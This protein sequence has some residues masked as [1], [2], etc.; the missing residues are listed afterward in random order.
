MTLICQVKSYIKN[1]EEFVNKTKY[2]AL[3]ENKKNQAL[4]C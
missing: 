2:E 3:N 4:V 1:F